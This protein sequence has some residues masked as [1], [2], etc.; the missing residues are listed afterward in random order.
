MH[1]AS[2]TRDRRRRR[3]RRRRR[4]DEEEDEEEHEEEHEEEEEEEEEDEEEAKQMECTDVYR[5]KVSIYW[6]RKVSPTGVGHCYNMCRHLVVL[7][8]LVRVRGETSGG[9]D[10]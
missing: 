1:L 2:R 6:V 9:L 8:Y 7:E 3:R 4:E 5:R 10:R